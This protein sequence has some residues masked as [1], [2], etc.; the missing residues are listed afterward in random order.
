MIAIS[1]QNVYPREIEEFLF[2]HAAVQEVQVF[3]VPDA[4]LGEEVCAW[5]R[6]RDTHAHV[7]GDALRQHCR[8]HIAHYKVPKYMRLVAEFPMTV[9]GKPQK[10]LM[11]AKEME[12]LGL[13]EVKTA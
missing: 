3:G 10:F 9:S 7:T 5:V 11:R 12:L 6:V 2:K 1:F 13:S 8:E 4:R